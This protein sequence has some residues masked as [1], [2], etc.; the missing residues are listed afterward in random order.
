MSFENDP[1]GFRPCHMAHSDDY[2]FVADRDT[3][4]RAY[5]FTA[6]GGVLAERVCELKNLKEPYGMAFHRATGT[7]LVACYGVPAVE[8]LDTRPPPA[9]W[10][11]HPSDRLGG[12]KKEGVTRPPISI[13][14]DE[15]NGF[16]YVATYSPQ[17][18]TQ[19]K[20]TV[21]TADEKRRETGG[22]TVDLKLTAVRELNGVEGGSHLCAVAVLSPSTLLLSHDKRTVEALTHSAVT[23]GADCKLAG[24]VGELRALDPPQT[25]TSQ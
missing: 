25:Q 5:R 6:D 19:Y 3:R 4:V 13:A 8:L 2:L 21:K 12:L 1:D 18:I 22:A 20:A 9:Q 11:F 10:R 17:T 15:P 23:E 24:P 14:I 16:V 7:L